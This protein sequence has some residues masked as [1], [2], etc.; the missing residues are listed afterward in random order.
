MVTLT[1]SQ[2]K[3]YDIE[4]FDVLEVLENNKKITCVEFIRGNFESC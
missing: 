2:I 3:V 1:D 4:N